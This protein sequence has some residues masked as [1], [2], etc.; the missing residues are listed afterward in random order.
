MY[1][2]LQC[3]Q[4]TSSSLRYVSWYLACFL[5]L[6]SSVRSFQ[7]TVLPSMFGCFEASEVMIIVSALCWENLSCF[8]RLPCISAVVWS[9]CTSGPQRLPQAP[10]HGAND[11]DHIA[12]FGCPLRRWSSA[13]SESSEPFLKNVH[14]HWLPVPSSC[15]RTLRTQRKCS[16][17]TWKHCVNEAIEILLGLAGCRRQI[18]Q[19]KRT[20][21]KSACVMLD[22]FAPRFQSNHPADW[23]FLHTSSWSRWCLLLQL[24]F[25]IWVFGK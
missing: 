10:G 22:Q 17:L 6:A 19:G 11:S 13:F 5:L 12:A 9:V 15:E 16:V 3:V 25:L 1:L 24:S 20:R 21:W 23:L 7:G 2:L 14:F 4:K 8:L 18:A